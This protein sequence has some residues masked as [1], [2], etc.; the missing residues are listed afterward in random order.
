ML[1]RY[2]FWFCENIFGGVTYEMRIKCVPNIAMIMSLYL[3]NV[4]VTMGYAVAYWVEALC[5]KPEGRGFDSQ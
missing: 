4:L 1:L 2:Y 5:Y 3:S